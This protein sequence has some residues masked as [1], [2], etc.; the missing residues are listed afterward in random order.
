[1]LCATPS[2]F[3]TPAI[4]LPLGG[5]SL[6]GYIVR[7]M[8]NTALLLPVRTLLN[9]GRSAEVLAQVALYA[10][11]SATSF[12]PAYYQPE[13]NAVGETV[14]ESDPATQARVTASLEAR[15]PH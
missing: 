5:M 12:G 15:S 8:H 3:P 11:V 9:E 6:L 10:T 7:Q 2:P 13:F 1:M 14:S 4:E